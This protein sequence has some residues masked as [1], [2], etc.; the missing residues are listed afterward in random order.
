MP[1]P[2]LESLRLQV[3][4]FSS[5][6]SA[7]DWH[8]RAS[9]IADQQLADALAEGKGATRDHVR[10]WEERRQKQNQETLS[11][12]VKALDSMPEV[13]RLLGIDSSS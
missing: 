1:K 2:N 7:L 12:I 6:E 5:I 3:S 9:N 10:A 13:K 8:V 11:T 4:R